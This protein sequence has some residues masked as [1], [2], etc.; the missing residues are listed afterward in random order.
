MI[1]EGTA[2]HQDLL[3]SLRV[4][5]VRAYIL[6]AQVRGVEGVFGEGW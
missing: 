4:S 1:A 3:P 6:T 5:Q 2:A